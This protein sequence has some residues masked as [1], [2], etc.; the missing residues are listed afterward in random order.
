MIER[1]TKGKKPATNYCGTKNCYNC[2]KKWSEEKKEGENHYIMI[3]E[4][5]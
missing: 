5:L 1:E 2:I 3:A 4:I